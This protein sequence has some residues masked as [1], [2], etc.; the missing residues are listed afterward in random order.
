MALVLDDTAK[1]A[2]SNTYCSRAN[3]DTYH[4]SVYRA[5]DWS[6][7]SSGNKDIALVEATRTLDNLVDWFGEATT[8][9][10]ALRAPRTGWYDPDGDE[11]DE[12]T[13]PGWL[14]DATAELARHIVASDL[15]ARPDGEGYK[16]IKADVVEV[17]RDTMDTPGVLPPSVIMMVRP[18]GEI[19][20]VKRSANRVRLAR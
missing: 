11:L 13:V 3:A 15:F 9:T 2:S 20:D 4:E 16:R 10:Q 14:R 17:E 7:A 8:T 19:R 18:Y 12:D 5:S 6:G 1:G